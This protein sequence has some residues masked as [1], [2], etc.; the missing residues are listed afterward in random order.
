MPLRKIRLAGKR[1]SLVPQLDPAAAHALILDGR[2]WSNKDRNS[3]YDKLGVEELMSRLGSW[4][5]VVRKRAA[6]ALARQDDVP[7]SALLTMLDSPSLESRYGACEALATLKGAAAPAVP[8]L[9]NTLRHDDLWLRVKATEALAGI[10]EPA[11]SAVPELLE[12]L[13]KGPSE[14]DPRGMEQRYL[15]FAVF[16]QML[17]RSLDGV[18][19]E[20]LRKAVAAGLQNQDGRARGTVGGIYQQLSYEE[21]KPLLP[22][23]HEA[24]V[25]PAPSGIMFASGVRLAGIDLLAK[26]RMREGMPLCIEVMEIQKW[27]KRHRISQCLKTLGQY[28]GAAKPMLPRLR[29]LE[30]ELLAHR[31]ARGLEPQIDQ[32]RALMKQIDSAGEPVELRSIDDR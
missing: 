2:G 8:A 29:Q 15:C 23:I 17:R 3:F 30:Q 18:D 11:M 9:K 28:G 12:M 16:G 32:L 14:N 21:I 31:E 6:M 13:A 10:G 7:I 20:P 25:T 26:H 19:R 22:A 5:P 27:G 24:I 1:S 4:S